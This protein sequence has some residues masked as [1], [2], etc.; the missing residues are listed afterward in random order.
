MTGE[1]A[2]GVLLGVPVSLVLVAAGWPIPLAGLTAGAAAALIVHYRP[3]R[4][5]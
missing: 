1:L 2:A 3:R 4:P 5:R